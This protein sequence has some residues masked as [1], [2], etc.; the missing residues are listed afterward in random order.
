MQAT[1]IAP[2][3]ATRTLP[4]P[5][6][7]VFA[8]LC[9]GQCRACAGS[10]RRDI[11]MPESHPKRNPSIPPRA[12]HDCNGTGQAHVWEG[13]RIAAMLDRE[14]ETNVHEPQGE[15]MRL[16]SPAPNQLAGQMSL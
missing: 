14:A 6:G 5:E 8:D 2:R 3:G 11:A 7:F 9:A 15:A 10:G 4:I 12:C 13:S 16:F 1:I